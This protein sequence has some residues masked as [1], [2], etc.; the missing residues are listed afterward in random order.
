MIEIRKQRR[1]EPWKAAC[2]PNVIERWL[3][4]EDGQFLC[5]THSESQAKKV[6]SLLDERH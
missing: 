4:L 2:D 3:V 6:K 1:H 5:E